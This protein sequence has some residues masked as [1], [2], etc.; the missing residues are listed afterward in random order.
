MS[1]VILHMVPCAHSYTVQGDPARTGAEIITLGAPGD[2]PTVQSVPGPATGRTYVM[3][4]VLP[5]GEVAHFG[6]AKTAVEFSD[7]TAV[8]NAGVALRCLLHF[9]RRLQLGVLVKEPA[10]MF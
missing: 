1:T 7:A 8:F 9:Q 6:G 5:T 3:S 4:V 2:P 10:E